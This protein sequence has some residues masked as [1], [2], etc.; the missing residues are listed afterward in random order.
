MARPCRRDADRT[1]LIGECGD[2]RGTGR[3]QRHPAADAV[4]QARAEFG[5]EQGDPLAD[6]GLRQIQRLGGLGEGF[7]IGD[8]DEGLQRCDFHYSW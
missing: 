2:Q 1:E 4:E 7:V 6:R 8:L 5:L 3:G